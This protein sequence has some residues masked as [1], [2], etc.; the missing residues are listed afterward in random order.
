MSQK[1]TIRLIILLHMWRKRG[2]I[3][4]HYFKSQRVTLDGLNNLTEF[5]ALKE[6]EFSF[7]GKSLE[8]LQ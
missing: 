4:V 5:E 2:K 6:L 8:V 1:E 7:F 3:G